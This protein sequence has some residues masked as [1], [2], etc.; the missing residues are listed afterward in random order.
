M[1][2]SAMMY[3]PING[4]AKVSFPGFLPGVAGTLSKNLWMHKS[5]AFLCSV[6]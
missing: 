5:S 4:G 3:C 2:R 1:H 6:F